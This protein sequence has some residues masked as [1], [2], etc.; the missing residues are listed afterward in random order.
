METF[1][2][3]SN[4]YLKTPIEAWYHSDYHNGGRWRQDGT[5]ENIICTLK[6]DIRI[7]PANDVD[8]LNARQRL[9]DI[10]YE[11]LKIMKY[12]HELYSIT[13]LTICVVPRAKVN[14]MP[15]QLLFKTTIRQ[16]VVALDLNDG[17]DYIIRTVDTR[18]THRNRSGFGG[19][20]MLP[21]VG[22]TRDTCA[23][24]EEVRGKDVLLIDDVYTRT[25]NID[26][27]AI[28]TLLDNGANSVLF[29]S[30]GRTTQM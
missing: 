25:I 15:H 18:T 2:I 21:Y 17:T 6:N 27:D 9:Y 8:L 12:Y 23:I 29:Y 10:L 22:I 14:Y 30:I 1:Q 28:Q 20:G 26:E 5:I 11:D 3:E 4:E 13:P 16:V 7:K 19:N 24:S